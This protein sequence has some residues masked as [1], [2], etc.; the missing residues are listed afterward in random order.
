MSEFDD[1]KHFYLDQPKE[2]SLETL[3]L[4]NAACTFCPYP[5]LERKGTKMSDALIDSV[6]EQMLDWTVPFYFSPFK[7]NE[8]LLDNRLFDICRKALNNPN[9]YLR[10]FT[11]GSPLTQRK[12]DE[13]KTL[14]RVE[15]LWISL[16]STV[17]EQYEQIMA[18]PFEKTAKRL[19]NLHEQDFPFPVVLS[20]VG[21]PNPRFVYDCQARWPKF[22]IS[23]IKNTGWLGYTDPDVSYVPNTPCPR[24]FELSIVADG[25]VALCCMDG[26]GEWAIGDI[27]SQTL[28]EVY[29]SPHWRDR[30]ERLISRHEIAP[31]DRCTY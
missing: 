28:L 5:T 10:I 27:N 14:K 1:L 12:I 23:V 22:G 17:S 26:T 24:W 20:T 13:I 16:N 18:I 25:K 3:A 9:L 30:R 15:H 8:P 21:F 4:C 2:V 7:V 29:N 19:D 11:N 31:C 6:I